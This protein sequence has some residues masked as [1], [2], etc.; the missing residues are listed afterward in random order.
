MADYVY[1]ARTATGQLKTGEITAV[2]E[3]NAAEL[4]SQHHL[5]LTKLSPKKEGGFDASQ[6]LGIFHRISMKDRVIFTRQLGT[7]IKSGLPIVQALHILSEQTANQRFSEVILDLSATVEGGGTFSSALAKYPKLFDRVY[8][9]LIKSGEASGHLEEILERLAEQQEKS[10]RLAGKVRGALMYPAFVVVALIGAAILMM[11]VVIPPLKA[12]FT[13]AGAQLPLAT[14][15]LIGAS[16]ALRGYWWLML[17]AVIALSFGVRQFLESE[18]G[19]VGWDRVK[20]RLPIF[21]PLFQKIYISRM[22]RTLSSLTGG[23]VPILNALDIVGESVGNSVYENALK[24]AAKDVEAGIPLSQPLRA[25]SAFPAMVPQM[26]SVGEQTGNLDGVLNKLADFYEEE[27][28]NTVKNLSTLMEP[29]L[30]VIMGIAVGGLL[31]AILMPIYNL[32]N[33][34]G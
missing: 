9:N 33:V 26:I 24:S 22:T 12:I 29:I 4:L 1:K 25:N 31:I 27:V 34:I 7:M 18:T 16:D 10:Y 28:D 11:I 17:P 23:G 8:V 30:M 14:R 2:S 6:I 19:K 20:L 3:E 5:I 15:M 13:E 32:G 21:G